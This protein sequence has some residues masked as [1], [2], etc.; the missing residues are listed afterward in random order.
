MFAYGLDLP[1]DQI[2]GK[3][4]FWVEDHLK[5]I[6]YNLFPVLINAC[7]QSDYNSVS[8]HSNLLPT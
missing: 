1:Q 8:L 3:K 6:C 4:L 7:S 2:G 5:L